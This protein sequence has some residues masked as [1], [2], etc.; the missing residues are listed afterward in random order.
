MEAIPGNVSGQNLTPAYNFLPVAQKFGMTHIAYASLSEDNMRMTIEYLPDGQTLEN[1]KRMFTVTLSRAP[2]E[3][4]A[5]QEQLEEVI[6]NMEEGLKQGQAEIH[7]FDKA[8]SPQGSTVLMHFTIE[9]EENAGVI[10]RSPGFVKIMQIAAR[11]ESLTQSDM[12]E[13]QK[14]EARVY[15][16][17]ATKH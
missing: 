4:P 12:D 2:N 14:L 5:A 11:G 15:E 8:E 10:M 3:E 6:A 7:T 17:P 16:A 1:W 9:G 13:V